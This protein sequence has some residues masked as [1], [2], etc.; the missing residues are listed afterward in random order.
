M[1]DKKPECHLHT[2]GGAPSV[3]R[4]CY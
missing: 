1:S 3:T 4:R 2:T